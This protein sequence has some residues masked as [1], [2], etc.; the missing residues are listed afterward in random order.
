MQ[1]RPMLTTTMAEP[2]VAAAVAGQS[3][4]PEEFLH[5]RLDLASNGKCDNWKKWKVSSKIT[6]FQ[7]VYTAHPEA[8]AQIFDLL[9]T[10]PFVN[11]RIDES[12]RPEHLL[13]VYRWFTKYESVKELH[14]HFGF[15]EVLI[16][17]LCK[18]LPNKVALL[19]KI[20]VRTSVNDVCLC[21]FIRL[22]VLFQIDPNW[23]DDDETVLSM[24][25]DGIHYAIDEPRPFSTSFGSY[26]HGKSAGLV[27]EYAIYTT[28]TKLHGLM[29]H[30]QRGKVTGK[31]LKQPSRG[32][33]KRSRK[34]AATTFVSLQ[35]MDT[36]TK[37]YCM[38]CH[39]AMNSI[40]QK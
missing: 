10:N 5:L 21:S 17:S 9:Q 34:N 7:S 6:H 29:G 22:I 31:S 4:S 20:L 39:S 3:L 25:L 19:R 37:S 33:L 23:E 40:R 24:T 18:D 36:L 1:Q 16:R 27:Y 11:D 12:T 26:K 28:R 2:V 15:G 38:C 35:T 14:A 8:L 13:L 32:R 30:F